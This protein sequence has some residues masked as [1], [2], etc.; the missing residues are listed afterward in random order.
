MVRTLGRAK[1]KLH[2]VLVYNADPGSGPIAPED[3]GS[4]ADLRLMIRR[5][6]RALRSVGYQV[7]ILALAHDLFAFQRRLRRLQPDVVFNQYDDVVHGALYEMRLPAVV[8]MMGYPVTG[9]PALALGLTRYKYMSAS[10]LHGAGI[11]IPPHTELL[12]KIGDVDRHKRQ[13]PLIV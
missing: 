9:S 2:V 13:F 4:T 7:T 12:E 1:K 3:R 6:A 11:P 5:M 10:L 8:R